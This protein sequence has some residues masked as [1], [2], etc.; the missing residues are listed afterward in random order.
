MV[1]VLGRLAKFASPRRKRQKNAKALRKEK[2]MEQFKA[3]DIDNSGTIDKDELRY[4]LRKCTGSLPTDAEVEAMMREIDR[5]RDGLIAFDEFATL[6][7]RAR[8][9]DLPFAALSKI[10]VDFD[11]LT[12]LVPDDNE[13]AKLSSSK[14]P[15]DL[16]KTPPLDD[17]P[18][19]TPPLDDPPPSTPPPP[20]QLSQRSQQKA[21]RWRDD[22]DDDDDDDDS[23]DDVVEDSVVSF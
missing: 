7:E 19:S 23:A 9:G 6:H 16:P 21:D 17:P 5:N 15:E 8:R 14:P 20:E 18:P 12:A 22:E 1:G 10:M 4:L 11:G 3:I 13:P 2:L